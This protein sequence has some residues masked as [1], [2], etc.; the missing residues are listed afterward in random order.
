MIVCTQGLHL[1]LLTLFS[2]RTWAVCCFTLSLNY[3]PLGNLWH[4]S[5]LMTCYNL[6]RSIT[7]FYY[8]LFHLQGDL[9]HVPWFAVVEQHWENRWI[10]VLEIICF[11]KKLCSFPSDLVCSWFPDQFWAQLSWVP[12]QDSDTDGLL[13]WI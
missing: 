1:D 9:V 13:K 2:I 11:L 8:L 6:V 10:F 7:H 5:S 12:A 3:W 4:L